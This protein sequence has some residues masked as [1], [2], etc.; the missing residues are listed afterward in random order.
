[1]EAYA[2]SLPVV[3]QDAVSSSE[4][5]KLHRLQREEVLE[6]SVN[7]TCHSKVGSGSAV[8][9]A[10]PVDVKELVALPALTE[11]ENAGWG[12]VQRTCNLLFPSV[13]RNCG[14]SDIFRTL[15]HLHLSQS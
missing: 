7:V 9:V 15:I 3:S 5:P 11:G 12:K 1:M 10:K 2:V 6:C 14:K 8:F 13:D 4:C